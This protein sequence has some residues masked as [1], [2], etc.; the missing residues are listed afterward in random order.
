VSCCHFFQ[1]V[2]NLFSRIDQPSIFIHDSLHTYEYMIWEFRA[3][4][5]HLP[6]GGLLFA[7][8]ALW[9]GSFADFAREVHASQARILRDPDNQLAQ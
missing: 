6:P 3:A 5:P 9:N 8:D 2:F 7:D 1:P 4:Y